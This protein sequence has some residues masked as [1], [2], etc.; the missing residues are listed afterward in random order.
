LRIAGNFHE[1]VRTEKLVAF[2]NNITVKLTEAYSE[3]NKT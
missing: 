1:V 2:L 3:Q